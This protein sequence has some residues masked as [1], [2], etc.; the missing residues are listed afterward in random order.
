M[1]FTDVSVTFGQGK[2]TV[3]ALDRVSLGFGRGSF[4]SVVGPSGCGKTTLLHVLAGFQKPSSGRVT[5]GG[6]EIR[7]TG[8]DRGVVFQQGALFP[9][10]TVAGNAAFGPRMRG[11]SR[12]EREERAGHW[13][14]V[15]G[16]WD[17]RDRYPY[18]LSGGMQQR[19]AIAR[20]LANDPAMLLMDE[21]FGALDALTRERMQEELQAVWR[22]SGMT[23]L[24]ITHS[25]EEAVFLGTD[26]VVMSPR[27]GRIVGRFPSP[28]AQDAATRGTRTVKSDQAFVA[29]REQVLGLI[30]EGAA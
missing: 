29:L 16:L 4:I 9:W 19:L 10:M 3:Q 22:S 6:T 15:V 28:F 14:R 5:V 7:G 23:L 24:F 27:P 13:L 20:A 2:D 11:A 1:A 30:L 8:A 12:R 17:F 18:E 25:V 26:V 21:P